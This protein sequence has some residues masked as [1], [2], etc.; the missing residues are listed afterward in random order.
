MYR[1]LNG[2]LEGF[3]RLE[4][5]QTQLKHIEY[6]SI[7]YSPNYN[8][9]LSLFGMSYVT[10]QRAIIFGTICFHQ[11]II[12][13]GS[14]IMLTTKKHAIIL[15]DLVLRHLK[16]LYTIS[17][18]KERTSSELFGPLKNRVFLGPSSSLDFLLSKIFFPFLVRGCRMF[19]KFSSSP[20]IKT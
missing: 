15:L 20:D 1:N 18:M 11:L 4:C 3:L 5:F 13:V 10:K 9:I 12:L 6:F 19:G 7:K 17:I 14:H 2:F 8:I 16:C